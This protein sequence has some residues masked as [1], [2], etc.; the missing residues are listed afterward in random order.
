MAMTETDHRNLVEKYKGMFNEE[1]RAALLP[2]RHNFSIL[3]DNTTKNLNAGVLVRNF[4]AFSGKHILFWK[5]RSWNRTAALGTYQYEDI[6]LIENI[7]MLHEMRECLGIDRIVAVENN[8]EK[9]I[10]SLYDYKWNKNEHVLIILGS[11]NGIDEPL[12]EIADD[13]IEIP[14]KGSVRSLNVGVVGGIL[15]FDYCSKME[16]EQTS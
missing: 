7:E 8:I 9:P 4:N 16:K 5:R 2:G 3:I 10:Q 14:Q 15:L 1:I 11:E 6:R 13:F 12:L